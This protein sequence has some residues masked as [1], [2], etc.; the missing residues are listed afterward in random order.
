[1]F[2]V[3]HDAFSLAGEQFVSREARH[4]RQS[5]KDSHYAN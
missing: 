5:G 3:K 4:T 1:M 2:H